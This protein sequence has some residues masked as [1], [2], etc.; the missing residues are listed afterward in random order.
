MA[1][2]SLT[3]AEARDKLRSKEISAVELTEAHIAA[4][5]QQATL[6]AFITPT[7]DVARARPRSRQDARRRTRLR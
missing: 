1:L 5:E 4:M 3:I 2:T 6:N 7:P